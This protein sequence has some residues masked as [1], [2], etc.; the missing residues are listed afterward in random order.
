MR[1]LLGDD[2]AEGDAEDVD[3]VVAE[4][5][6]RLFHRPRD[7]G[8]PPWP[9]VRAG[10]PDARRVEADRLHA[11]RGHLPFERRAEVEACPEPGD[12]EQGRSESAY[13]RA[14]PD[15]VGVDEPDRAAVR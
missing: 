8:H 13:R 9:A 7:A 3:A 4:R 5:V 1:E 14:Y 6:K 2:S 12:Q 10:F 15:A 11:A